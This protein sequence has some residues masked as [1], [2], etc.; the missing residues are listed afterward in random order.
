MVTAE[1]AV[2]LPAVVLVLALSLSALTLGVDAVRCQ[3]AARV[4]VRELARGEGVDRAEGDAS[5][6]LPWGS[7]VTSSRSGEVVTVTA[8]TPPPR[9]LRAIGIAEGARCSSAAR[10]EAV[11]R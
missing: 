2:A 1:T 5:R 6:A 4:A 11:T 7:Q 3:D 9:L 10:V 8:R